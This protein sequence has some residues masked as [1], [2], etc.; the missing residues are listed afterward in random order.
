MSIALT[1]S[2]FLNHK[3]MWMNESKCSL[4]IISGDYAGFN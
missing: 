2:V 4:A 1:E 3:I